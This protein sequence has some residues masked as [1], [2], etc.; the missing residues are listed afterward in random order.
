MLDGGRIRV[1]FAEPQKSVTPGQMVVKIVH[2]ELVAMLGADAEPISLAA[3]S[4]VTIMMVGLH[5]PSGKTAP[6]DLRSIADWVIARRLQSIP[7]IAEVLAGD[8][9]D[10]LWD[11]W[12]R[13]DKGLDGYAARRPNET[14]VVVLT[15]ASPAISTG[16]RPSSTYRARSHAGS[17]PPGR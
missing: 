17:I 12:R 1:D 2:D 6:R 4:P 5:D 9:R 15:P 14:A 8:E 3:A 7:G 16:D 13:L 10:R 11:R